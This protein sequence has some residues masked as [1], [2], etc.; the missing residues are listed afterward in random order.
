MLRTGD[1]ASLKVA[2][3]RVAPVRLA[4]LKVAM[5]GCGVVGSEVYRLLVEQ[6]GDLSARAGGSLEVAGIAVSRPGLGRSVEVD[7]SL[8]TTD[9]MALVTHQDVDI[10]VEL[11]GGIE[12]ARSLLLAALGSGNGCQQQHCE[13]DGARSHDG[14]S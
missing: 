5:L 4:P 11:I 3:L 12:P 9:G 1:S 13:Q 8:L 7:Q 10:V 6:A 2:S 14:I